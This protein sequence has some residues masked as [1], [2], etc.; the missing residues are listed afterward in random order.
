[1]SHHPYNHRIVVGL[2]R[3]MADGERFSALVHRAPE[4]GCWAEVPAIP[5]CAT[6][7][8]SLLKLRQ[9]LR[10]A[11]S[12]CLD[13]NDH[14]SVLNARARNAGKRTHSSSEVRARLGLVLRGF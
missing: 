3:R 11:I 1:M 10:E 7:A 8:E 14:R 6:Q 9:N 4:G 12:G 2:G 13:A 5:G